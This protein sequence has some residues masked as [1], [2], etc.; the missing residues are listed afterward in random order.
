MI[1]LIPYQGIS[2]QTLQ[3]KASKA[4][5]GTR[6]AV[7]TSDASQI[8]QAVTIPMRCFLRRLAVACE[9]LAMACQPRP[10]GARAA[11]GETGERQA[12]QAI[13]MEGHDGRHGRRPQASQEEA[14]QRGGLYHIARMYGI[15]G[16]CQMFL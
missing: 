14:G 8:W 1:Q 3:G 9:S 5:Q 10:V 15:V 16:S 6:Q 11:T 4:R 12:S 13:M 7:A 2:S